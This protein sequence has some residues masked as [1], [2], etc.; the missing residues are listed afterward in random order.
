MAGGGGAEGTM[1]RVTLMELATMMGGKGECRDCDL[2]KRLLLEEAV[3]VSLVWSS[4]S[5]LEGGR[6]VLCTEGYEG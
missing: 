2:R 3:A 5:A 4:W 1:A 6:L